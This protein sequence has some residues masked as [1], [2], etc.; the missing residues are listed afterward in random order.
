MD[1]VV[2][3]YLHLAT[4]WEDRYK[5]RSVYPGASALAEAGA[6]AYSARQHARWQTIAAVANRKFKVTNPKYVCHI[7]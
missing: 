7:M 3:Y 4:V 1:W 5:N 6:V 2:R